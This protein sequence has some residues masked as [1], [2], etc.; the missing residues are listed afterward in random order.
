[1]FDTHSI[2]FGYLLRIPRCSQQLRIHARHVSISRYRCSYHTTYQLQMSTPVSAGI[3][4]SIVCSQACISFCIQ[5]LAAPPH[6]SLHPFSPRYRAVLP[7]ITQYR[8]VSSCQW[9]RSVSSQ[10]HNEYHVC[11]GACITTYHRSILE[12]SICAY[13][14]VSMQVS[15]RQCAPV[16]LRIVSSIVSSTD[17]FQARIRQYP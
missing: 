4:D 11:I 15:G 16:S 13:H 14:C 6:P 17:R 1:M 12:L 7:S 3:V 8:A 5:S 9:Y 2:L 10:Y